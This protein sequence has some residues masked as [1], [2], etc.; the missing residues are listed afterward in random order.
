MEKIKPQDEILILNEDIEPMTKKILSYID[1]YMTNHLNKSFD[2]PVEKLLYLAKHGFAGLSD[3]IF[4]IINK[5]DDLRLIEKGVFSKETEVDVNAQDQEGNTLLHYLA[6]SHHLCPLGEYLLKKGANASVFN[7]KGETALKKNAHR[8]N[9][10]ADALIFATSVENLNKVYPD[11]ETVLTSFVQKGCDCKLEEILFLLQKA[12]VDVNK[13]NIQD[14]TPLYYLANRIAESEKVGPVN[15]NLQHAFLMMVEQGAHFSRDEVF[16]LQI[17]DSLEKR[18]L[19]LL[20]VP[21]K[22][23]KNE[24]NQEGNSPLHL[25]IK[26]N[27]F[28]QAYCQLKDLTGKELSFK[29]I[30]KCLE[31]ASVNAKNNYNDM[32]LDLIQKQDQMDSKIALYLI[33][34][35]AR[36]T[37]ERT[38]TLAQQLYDANGDKFLENLIFR[39]Y[40]GIELGDSYFRESMC[41]DRFSSGEELL[42]EMYENHSKGKRQQEEERLARENPGKDAC[43]LYLERKYGS[44]RDGFY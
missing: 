32:P 11:G 19:F 22:E 1:D 9:G 27:A 44:R 42:E 17:F 35:G 7:Q 34:K 36:T 43:Q 24:H 31:I 37:D 40:Q 15:P 13:Q 26:L 3:E 25:M 23:F 29:L 2:T 21:S 38:K 33:E 16:E 14:H 20:G 41:M 4:S 39:Y 30:D 10:Y 12:G 8:L 28:D 6:V 18:P 5:N